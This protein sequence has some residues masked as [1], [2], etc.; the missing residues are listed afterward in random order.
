MYVLANLKVGGDWQGSPDD[1][2]LFPN[3]MDIDYIRVY[4]KK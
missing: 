1:T 4:S 3:T 2:T